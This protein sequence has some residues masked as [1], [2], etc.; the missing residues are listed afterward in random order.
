MEKIII[1]GISV[2]CFY[3]LTRLYKKRC[4]LDDKVN[5]YQMSDTNINELKE[6]ENMIIKVNTPNMTLLRCYKEYNY[7][8]DQ[9]M[10]ETNRHFYGRHGMCHNFDDNKFDRYIC[11]LE[12][13]LKPISVNNTLIEPENCKIIV[14][15]TEPYHLKTYGHQLI[16]SNLVN[17]NAIEYLAKLNINLDDKYDIE[18]YDTGDVVYINV[19][20]KDNKL[21]YDTVSTSL[22]DIVREKIYR[23]KFN[24]NSIESGITCVTLFG[25]LFYMIK[26]I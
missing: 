4:N 26:S 12:M 22:N 1:A 6:G 25:T 11:D 23:N 15:N 21:V 14:P 7:D 18:R 19:T 9:K 10:S 16:N 17:G 24:R 13:G 20:R 3:N 5:S 8:Y 2:A